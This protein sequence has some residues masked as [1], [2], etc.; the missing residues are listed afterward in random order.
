MFY[1]LC[2]Q[3]WSKEKHHQQIVEE[4]ETQILKERKL[5]IIINPIRPG[6]FQLTV[7][8]GGGGGGVTSQ[9]KSS[10]QRKF[11]NFSDQQA[12]KL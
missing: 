12:A 7:R 6:P 4:T 10:Q 2:C 8:P 5:R 3:R 1:K 11:G 9:F